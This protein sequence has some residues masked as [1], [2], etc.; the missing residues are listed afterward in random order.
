MVI[1]GALSRLARGLLGWSLSTLAVRRR[2]G[3]TTIRNF[4]IGRHRP[5][6]F[7]VLEIKRALEVG[8]IEFDRKGDEVRLKERAIPSPAAKSA[9]PALCYSGTAP[10]VMLGKISCAMMAEA[11]RGHSRILSVQ[12]KTSQTSLDLTSSMRAKPAGDVF[13]FDREDAHEAFAV[14]G[15]ALIKIVSVHPHVLITRQ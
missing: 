4:E 15:A 2:V 9:K 7:K 10:G 5:A 11:R 12:F 14:I 3:E 13:V 8:E 1:S 6:P